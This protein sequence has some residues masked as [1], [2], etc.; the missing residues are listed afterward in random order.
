MKYIFA[1]FLCF[2]LL[3]A[4]HPAGAVENTQPTV[5]PHDPNADR[6]TTEKIAEDERAAAQMMEMLKMMEMLQQIDLMEDYEIFGE[7]KDEKSS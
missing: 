7:N 6:P 3:A 1:V 5:T 2:S 4:T